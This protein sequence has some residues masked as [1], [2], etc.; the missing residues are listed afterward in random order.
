[1]IETTVDGRYQILARVAAGGMGEVYRAHDPVLGREVALKI[2]HTSLADDPGFIDRFRREARSAAML[3]HPNIV[4]IHDWG[5]TQGTYFMVMEF[6]RGPNLRALL[7]RDG[8]L[9]P[10]QAAEIVSDV[11][12]A[13]EHA[14]R[15]G[16]VHR[17]I[18]PENVMIRAA[19][20]TVKVADFGLARAFADSRVSQAPG[21]VT[22]TVQYLAPEQIEGMPA[23][24]RTDLYATGI[25]LYELLTGTVPFTGETSVAIAYRHLRDRV[26]PPSASNPMVP[27][28]LD[29]VVLQATERDRERR[30]AGAAQMRAE[31][32]TAAAELPPAPPLAEAAADAGPGDEVAADRLATVTIPRP[33]TP[34]ARRRQRAG[35][36]L[37]IGSSVIAAAAVAWAVWTFVIPHPTTVPD[38]R[39]DTLAV[40]ETEADEAGLDLVVTLEQFHPDVPANSI[41]SQSLNPGVQAETGDELSVVLSRGPQLEPVP[42]VEGLPLAAARRQ[43]EEAGFEEGRVTRVYDEAVLEGR[44]IDQNPAPGRELEIGEG[45]DLRVSRGPEPVDLPTVVGRSRQDAEDLLE[46]LNLSV[47]VTQEYSTVPAGQVIRQSPPPGEEVDQESVV[48]IVVSKGPRS[49]PMPNVVTDP[50][51]SRAQVESQL[52]ALGLQVRVVTVP[53]SSGDVVVGQEPAAGQ[54]VQTGQVVTVYVG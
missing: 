4:G 26:P 11:L 18:K 7:L 52:R 29:R 8:S 53:N 10:A 42:Q 30:T 36:F 45:V 20:G 38:L 9:Q 28:S 48:T 33:L 49:F 31:L 13:L 12:S 5:E 19:D 50:P 3:S 47:E 6:V 1:M 40:A 44:V 35:R 37:R 41:I 23:D 17:D 34:E 2:L 21:T 25:V 24:P 51:M 22:G 54:I 27:A 46:A 32:T 15:Q 16:I 39:G 43:I 14:H